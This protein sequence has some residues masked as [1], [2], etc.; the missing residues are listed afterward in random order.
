MSAHGALEVKTPGEL[1]YL[2]GFVPSTFDA[3]HS[4]LQ[5]SATWIGMG[6]ILVSLAGFGTFVY[7]F[8]AGSD[9]TSP[10][11]D[12]GYLIGWI[13]LAAALLAFILGG[14]CVR[15][16]RRNYRAYTKATGRI[17]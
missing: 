6:L 13:G 7:G 14:V 11:A 12:E 1:D 3:P 10:M 5:R 9:T 2:D 4:S 16:G 8:A 15:I 17:Q